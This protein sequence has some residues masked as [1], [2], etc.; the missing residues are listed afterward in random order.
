MEAQEHD[1]KVGV[2][3]TVDSRSLKDVLLALA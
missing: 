3:C 2:P 1:A